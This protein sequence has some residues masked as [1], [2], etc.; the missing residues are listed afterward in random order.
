MGFQLGYIL[1]EVKGGEGKRTD[2]YGIKSV[3][4]EAEGE[5]G[6]TLR[7]AYNVPVTRFQF[8]KSP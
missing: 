3:A 5:C 2:E 4:V 8:L 7:I 6:P 1:I